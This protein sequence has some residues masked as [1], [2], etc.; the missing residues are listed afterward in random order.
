VERDAVLSPGPDFCSCCDSHLVSVISSI[1]SLY[2]L[3]SL[4]IQDAGGDGM[5]AGTNVTLTLLD[6]NGGRHTLASVAGRSMSTDVQQELLIVNFTVPSGCSFA[7]TPAP[8]PSTCDADS[9]LRE[10]KTTS[11][12]KRLY[13]TAYDCKNS[14]GGICYCGAGDPGEICG[15]L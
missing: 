12:C 10:C 4:S 5:G 7:P 2:C 6:G 13:P 14:K 1:L 11:G 9:F 3:Q 8:A 15:C